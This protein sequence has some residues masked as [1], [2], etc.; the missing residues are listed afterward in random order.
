V[1]AI[2]NGAVSPKINSVSKIEIFSI[3]LEDSTHLH[4]TAKCKKNNII[5]DTT[6]KKHGKKVHLSKR[7]SFCPSLPSQ[8]IVD[9]SPLL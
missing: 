4:K 1:P 5:A 6:E 9:G 7:S 3:S 2:Y 8:N